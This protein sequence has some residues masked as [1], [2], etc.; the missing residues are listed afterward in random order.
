MN[1]MDR[2]ASSGDMIWIVQW[3]ILTSIRGNDKV[4]HLK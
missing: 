2:K 3:I 4:D 1:N